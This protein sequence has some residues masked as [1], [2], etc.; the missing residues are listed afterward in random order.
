MNIL[1]YIEYKNMLEKYKKRKTPVREIRTVAGVN[2]IRNVTGLI[3]RI[4]LLAPIVD[5]LEI[6]DIVDVFCPMERKN[7]GGL[8]HGE[9]IEM[10]IYN[11]EKTEEIQSAL[12]FKMMGKCK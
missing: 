9:V 10:L 1:F 11:R 3:G 7:S 8:S 4:P 5:K 2:A 12:S 6:R